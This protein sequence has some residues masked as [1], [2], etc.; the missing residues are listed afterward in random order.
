MRGCGPDSNG[1]KQGP[2]AGSCEHSNA[3]AG[4]RKSGENHVSNYQL[5]KQDDSAPW[6]EEITGLLIVR[7]GEHL[8]LYNSVCQKSE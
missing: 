1:S 3:S 5:L 4:S 8:F 7:N 6:S 2:V